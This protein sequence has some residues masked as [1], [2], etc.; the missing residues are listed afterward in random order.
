MRSISRDTPLIAW[1]AVFVVSQGNIVRLLGPAGPRVLEIQTAWSAR[2]YRDILAGMDE[3]T[4]ARFRSHYYPDFVHPAIYAAALR[5]GATRLG[6]LTPLSPR[7]KTMLA[8]A[9]V[10]SA[11]GDYVENLVGL[12]LLD[13]PE[14]ITDTVVRTTTAVSTTKWLLALGSLAYLGVG[15][16][17]VWFRRLTH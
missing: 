4:T 2:R 6:E 7:A 17:R 1:S 16:G 5:A 13:H 3:K 12:H 10:A 14:H 15:F 11:A 9:P 8:L